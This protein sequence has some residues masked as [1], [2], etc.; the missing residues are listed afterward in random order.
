MD[1]KG[2]SLRRLLM[3]SESNTEPYRGIHFNTKSLN[4][5]YSGLQRRVVSGD[6]SG[7]QRV[8]ELYRGIHFNIE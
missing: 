2:S 3:T 1:Y 7:L 5:N 6:Y 4:R 8:I